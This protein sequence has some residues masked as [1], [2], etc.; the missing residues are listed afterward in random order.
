MDKSA[1]SKKKPGAITPR[2]LPGG[3]TTLLV[4]GREHYREMARKS[5]NKR[6][7]ALKV[8]LEQVRANQK[9]AVEGL[10]EWHRRRKLAKTNPVDEL[11]RLV[12]SSD[13]PRKT[14]RSIL[15]SFTT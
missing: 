5:W 8:R 2:P 15:R 3:M 7:K 11:I 10:K 13:N 12:R 9:K 6:G 14:A 1:A 4:H